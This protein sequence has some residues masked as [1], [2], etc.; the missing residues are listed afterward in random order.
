MSGHTPPVNGALVEA[1]VLLGKKRFALAI[2]SSCFPSLAE[3][4]V[5]RGSP[6]GA[7]AIAFLGFVR[8]LGFNAIQLGPQGQSTRDNPSPYDG[9]LFSCNILDLDLA[10]LVRDAGADGALLDRRSWQRWVH[11]R[12][13]GD[14]HSH[15]T[16]AYDVCHAALAD[17]HRRFEQERARGDAA[18]VELAGQLAAFTGANGAW[19][20]ADA[21]YHALRERHGGRHHRHWP[22]AG[23]SCADAE[24]YRPAPEREAA[25]AIRRAQLFA[26]HHPAVARY[27]LG[28]FLLSRQHARFRATMAR[29]GMRLYGDL[30]VGISPCDAWRRG[31]LYLRDY[32]M[33][34]PPSR[35]NPLG[36]P[37]GYG[38]LDPAQYT[39]GRGGP[40]PVLAFLSARVE[41][42]LAE[43]DGLRIDHPH[44]LVCP[45]VYR[46]DD[47]DPFHAVQHGAR[48]FSSPVLPDH[49]DLARYSIVLPDQLDDSLPR[50]ADDWVRELQPHQVERYA[51]LFDTLVEAARKHGAGSEDILCEVLSTLPHP[52]ARVIARQ[53]LGRFRVTQKAD[54]D[55]PADVYRSENARSEDWIMVGNHDTPP[56]W[57]LARQWAANGQARRQADYL[58]QRLAPPSRRET[59]AR[60][61][62]GD[63]RK[64][65]HAKF[66]DIFAS[67]AAQVMV[68]FADLLGLEEI[69]NRPGE[70]DARNWTLRVPPDYA[71]RYEQAVA[72]GEALDLSLALALALAARGEDF[73]RQHRD[74]IGHLRASARWWPETVPS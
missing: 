70:V 40:G 57:L 30:Q 66:A 13:P 12:P 36:Q 38:V 52:L 44:G 39:D 51:L 53:G 55:K 21:L 26:H 64:L 73:A 61:L 14:G 34:A 22:A 5:G 4:D 37:W 17:I 41:K 16:Y 63:W 2:H 56:L 23:A 74:L 33:G 28:Q 72:R 3:E 60:E 11:E 42:M 58:A 43:F 25:C 1:L 8:S 59:F 9:T 20:Q 27:E 65:A 69:Y 31:A 46:R 19:L 32:H 48:L 7:G 6:Y 67:P 18:A 68:F 71:S 24:L 62:A 10:A 35:T 29:W 49:P 50:Y 54:L 47:P 45:W 15:H